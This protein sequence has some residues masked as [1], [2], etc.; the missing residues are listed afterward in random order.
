M[1]S[2]GLQFLYELFDSMGWDN[3]EMEDLEVI[4]AVVKRVEIKNPHKQEELKRYN[5]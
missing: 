5:F 2:E 4:M 3:I 1:K